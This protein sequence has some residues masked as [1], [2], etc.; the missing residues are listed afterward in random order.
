MDKPRLPKWLRKILPW[1]VTAILLLVVFQKVGIR[2]TLHELKAE[3]IRNVFLLGF[4]FYIYVFFVN[5]LSY[6]V[7]FRQMGHGMPFSEILSIRGASYLLIALNPGVGQGG[8]AFWISRK[9]DIPLREVISFML[10]LPVVDATFMAGI[11]AVSLAAD[12]L[13]GGIIPPA[14]LTI[15]SGVMA[16][17]WVILIFH[18]I[19]WR[20]DFLSG[21][22]R[23][24]KENAIFTGYRKAKASEYISLLFVRLLMHVPGMLAYYAGLGLFGIEIPFWVFAVRFI[25][26]ILIQALPVT[27]GQLG[28]SQSA[29]ILMYQDYAA[30]A[31]LAAFSLVWITVYN[32]SRLLIGAICFREEA[33][34][35]FRNSDRFKAA[36]NAPREDA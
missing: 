27:V 29:W 33:R 7:L 24:I 34:Y 8:L 28:T 32:L 23:F 13:G 14:H 25:P 3:T 9:K 30:P 20:T 6:Y 5:G 17:L 15:L 4:T 22:L 2:E 16:V 35:F 21:S 31:T 18:F 1:I 19:F 36:D 10:M 12:L 26:T 11:L